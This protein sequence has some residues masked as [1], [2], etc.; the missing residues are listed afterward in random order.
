[1]PVAASPTSPADL[2]RRPAR[3]ACMALCLFPLQSATL[4]ILDR[5]RAPSWQSATSILCEDTRRTGRLLS[6]MEIRAGPRRFTITMR[7]PG[8]QPFWQA[9]GRSDD[10]VG[11]RRRDAPGIR[12]GL[13][14]GSG[15]NRSWGLPVTAVPGPN[16]AV[17]ALILSGLPPLPFM[18]LGF[19][20]PKQAAR[21]A[22]F[23][24]LRAA[25]RAGLSAR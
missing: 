23:S 1:M 10:R 13:S 8:S 25:E 21:R 19:P 12:S 14:A 3:P 18:F 2:A 4:A 16:A 11:F 17:T 22:A 7:M 6:A 5:V 9:A 15:G 24:G 20:P